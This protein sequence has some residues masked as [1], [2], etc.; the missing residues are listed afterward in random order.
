MERPGVKSALGLVSLV[1]SNQ[2]SS[3]L[4]LV[5]LNLFMLPII[6]FFLGNLL[7]QAS[8]EIGVERLFLHSNHL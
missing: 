3:A 1:A 2:K 6:P 5:F 8:I 4:V 7:P